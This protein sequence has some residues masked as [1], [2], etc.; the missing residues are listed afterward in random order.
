MAFFPPEYKRFE[1]NVSFL[2]TVGLV[3]LYL[4]PASVFMGQ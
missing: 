2:S 3:K 1:E 4:E